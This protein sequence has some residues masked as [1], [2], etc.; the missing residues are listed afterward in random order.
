MPT[1]SSAPSTSQRWRRC[2]RAR[3][4][5]RARRPSRRRA[6]S[7]PSTATRAAARGSRRGSCPAWATRGAAAR[8]AGRTR[9]PRAHP[10]PS[11]CS[12]S[13]SDADVVRRQRRLALGVLLAAAALAVAAFPFRATSWGGFLL[14]VAEAGVVGGP[15]D[16]FAVPPIFRRPLGLP[17]P[18]TALIPANWEGLAERVGA[19]VGG[20]VLTPSYVVQE[21][22]RV[23]VADLLARG[24][25]RVSQADLETATRAVASW[26]AEQ[27]TPATASELVARLRALLVA[28]PAAPTLAAALRIARDNGWGGRGGQAIVLAPADPLEGPAVRAPLA[29]GVDELLPPYPPR[30]GGYP[31]P[32]DGPAELLRGLH[33][34]RIVTAP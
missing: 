31:P 11:A 30:L 3:S 34:R 8:R 13:C 17:I 10:P 18:H 28:Q 26:A 9:I 6:P 29:Q 7:T 4:A 22:E 32:L 27:L 24:A 5:R 15:A 19:M 16:W 33:P 21:I 20:R 12:T 2:S 25:E 23:D 14:A 1:R